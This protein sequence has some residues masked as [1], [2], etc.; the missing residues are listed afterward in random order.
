MECYPRVFSIGFVFLS[1]IIIACSIVALPISEHLIIIRHDFFLLTPLL[2]MIQFIV[3]VENVIPLFS[4][5]YI[6][7][8]HHHI[9]L[10]HSL[11]LNL[12][13]LFLLL[14]TIYT[15]YPIITKQKLIFRKCC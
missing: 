9:L 5:S 8:K 11:I 1:Y 3:M 4:K 10:L 15:Q 6:S 14:Y 13:E 12:I 2:M 7:V